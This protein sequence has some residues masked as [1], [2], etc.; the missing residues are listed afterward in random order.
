MKEL[1]KN[2]LEKEEVEEDPVY[3]DGEEVQEDEDQQ[4]IQGQEME[5][6]LED[7]SQKKVE[8]ELINRFGKKVDEEEKEV[9]VVLPMPEKGVINQECEE[10]IEEEDADEWSKMMKELAHL[11]RKKKTSEGLS[12]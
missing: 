1:E 10:D 7:E 9:K 5:S 8:R 3:L 4:E 11:R 6:K 2:K 12:D